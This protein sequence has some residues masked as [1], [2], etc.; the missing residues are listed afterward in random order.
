MN[1]YFPF[2]VDEKNLFNLFLTVYEYVK[3]NSYLQF[4]LKP[5]IKDMNEYTVMLSGT[6][7][8]PHE[9]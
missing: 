9:L 2:T 6:E 4:C 1:E 8:D 3:C 7:Q 5:K